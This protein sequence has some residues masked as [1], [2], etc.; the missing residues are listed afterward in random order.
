M[1]LGITSS[2]LK[3]GWLWGAIAGLLAGAISGAA[4]TTF[5]TE[6]QLAQLSAQIAG[7]TSTSAIVT[8][9]EIEI[10]PIET[11]PLLTSL[12]SAFD[13]RRRS[14]VLQLLEI[15]A[16]E[17][18]ITQEQTIGTAISVTSDGWLV[19]S[20]EALAGAKLSNLRIASAGKTVAIDR[21][22]HDRHTDI[23]YLKIEASGLSV[24]DFVQAR[25][26]T[27]GAAAWTE[28]QPSVLRP[29]S[30]MSVRARRE[31]V[32]VSSESSNRRF[33]ISGNKEDGAPGQPVWDGRGKLIGLYESYSES[34][35]AWLVQPV[36]SIA[37]DLANLLSS[38]SI[39][40]AGLSIF[41]LD[42]EDVILS[43]RPEGLPTS[44][45]WL[46]PGEGGFS[47]AKTSPAFGKLEPSDVIE[48]I[49]RDILE[50]KADL[51]EILLE[52]RPDASVVITILRGSERMEV[53]I[54]LE[55]METSVV[56]K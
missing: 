19:T 2:R 52:Y 26:V 32:P 44:G 47:I 23:V 51:G 15:T 42:L 25:D 1:K 37:R 48:R 11:R 27:V 34:T 12:P 41:A 8:K 50:G 39:T 40:H 16:G 54:T 30:I 46:R 17:A 9:P 29:A 49:E 13:E 20:Y 4:I 55:E 31:Y 56:L 21:A 24:A 7:A 3:S 38:G 43:S 5:R 53:D 18:P 35:G 22:I 28:R 45:A 14:P 6:P 36:G 10:I 33:L